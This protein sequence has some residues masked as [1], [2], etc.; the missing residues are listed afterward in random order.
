M[1]KYLSQILQ[2]KDL[3]NK[4]LFTLAMIVVYRAI[5]HITIPGVNL[6]ALQEVFD[7]N[8]ILGAFSML[9][10]GST[11]NFSIVLMGLSPYINAVIIMQLL[12]VIVPRMEAL[13]KEGEQGRKKITQYTRWLTVPMAFIQ[14]YGMILLINSQSNAEII[15]NMGSPAVLLPIML[16]ITTGT[17]LLM[18]IGELITEKGISNGVSILIFSGIIAGLPGMAGQVLALAMEDNARLIPFTA[19]IVITVMLAIVIILVTEGQRKIPVTYA[20]RSGVSKGEQASLPIRI[21]QAGM[22]PIIFAVSMITFPGILGQFMVNGESAWV[23]KTGEFL[24]SAFQVGTPLY[25]S[26]YVL[27][28]IAFTYFYVSITFNPVEVADN[29]QKRGGFVP[30]IRP[31]KQTAE[32]LQKVSNRLNLFGGVFI[33]FIAVMPIL[34]QKTLSGS[35]MGSIPMLI[36]GAGMIIVVGVVLELIRQINAQLIMH[37]YEKFY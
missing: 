35:S 12:T 8:K 30:G 11:K 5:S 23:I 37:N 28:I 4:L 7:R 3:R 27:L 26:S 25:L 19:G 24:Q 10:G 15:T 33:A 29:I 20:G 32:Y 16:T 13:S 9:T 22:I 1:F 34:M 18:W 17:L 36:S 31:G 6:E 2:A 21:N 14:S